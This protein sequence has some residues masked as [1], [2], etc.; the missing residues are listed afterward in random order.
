[1]SDF[2][3]FI[4][5][6]FAFFIFLNNFEIKPIKSKICKIHTFEKK[7]EME[8]DLDQR[9]LMLS[10]INA[11]MAQIYY[12][13]KNYEVS[14]YDNYTHVQGYL[15]FEIDKYEISYINNTETYYL[16]KKFDSSIQTNI[17]ETF[18]E[19][20]NSVDSLA[21]KPSRYPIEM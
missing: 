13:D 16:Y 7:F 20:S 4:F 17:N 9:L 3:G 6:V 12:L 19:F 15:C 8:N 1:M 14:I 10:N 18:V 21:G 11:S 2:F 5:F